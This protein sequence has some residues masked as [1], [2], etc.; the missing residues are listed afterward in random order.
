V[1]RVDL[2]LR[3][4]PEVTPIALPVD[5]AISHYES[6]AL[7]WERAAFIRAR[8]AAGDVALGQRFLEAIEPFVW[9][10][11]LDFGVIEE[12]R[13]I[14]ARIRD[15]FAQ[16]AQIG[17]GYDLKRGRGGIRE[18]EFFVQIQQMIHGGRDPSVR[19]SAT[20]DA[21][22]ALIAADRL[23]ETNAHQLAET[24]RL[25]RT[26]EHRVQMVDDAQ[27]HLL[28]VEPAALD[29]VAKLHGLKCGDDL[30]DLLRPH[31]EQAGRTFDSLAP[32]E[33][34]QLSNDSDILKRE[35]QDLGFS[36]PASA[37]RHIA[38]WR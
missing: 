18:A 19:T 17:P 35:L 20:F 11:S 30:L 10:R 15:H 1:Q 3:P 9:R 36:D 37:A 2:R 22:E 6:S 14:S 33:R 27:T 28:P 7:P 13:Q 29:N 16:N 26:I 24:Y 23:D 21:I 32:E 5:A 34:G 8:A 4:S 31:V 38:D 25:L 12:V